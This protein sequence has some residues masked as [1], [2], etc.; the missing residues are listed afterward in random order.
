MS[1]VFIAYSENREHTE[2]VQLPSLTRLWYPR[3]KAQLL[4]WE[5][6]NKHCWTMVGFNLA[7]AK[8]M[9]GET[10]NNNKTW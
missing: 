7:K 1:K 6:N 8:I 3:T 4:W 10:N 2:A 9:V 5:K